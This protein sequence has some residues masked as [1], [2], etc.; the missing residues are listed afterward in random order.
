M[1]LCGNCHY[2]VEHQRN[3]NHPNNIDVVT[4]ERTAIS[5][6]TMRNI[7]GTCGPE[8]RWFMRKPLAEPQLHESARHDNRV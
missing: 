4:G 2:L 1:N 5:C 8:G 6:Y 7:G 3:C